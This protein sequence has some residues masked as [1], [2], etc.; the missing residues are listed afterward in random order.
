LSSASSNEEVSLLISVSN[1]LEAVRLNGK[2]SIQLTESLVD[3]VSNLTKEVT[4]L[5]QDNV[6]IKQEIKKVCI[7]LLRPP[8]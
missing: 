5:K 3:M 1:Q 7:R 2:S 8:S 6:L 4:H